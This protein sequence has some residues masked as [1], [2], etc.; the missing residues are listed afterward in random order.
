MGRFDN[1]ETLRPLDG[2]SPAS[3]PRRAAT[4]SRHLA[5][6]LL[7]DGQLVA[8]VRVIDLHTDYRPLTKELAYHAVAGC[9][10]L[11]GKKFQVSVVLRRDIE[12]RVELQAI[13]ADWPNPCVATM[14]VPVNHFAWLGIQLGDESGLERGSY[15]VHVATLAPNHPWVTTGTAGNSDD[16][17]IVEH[18]A[19]LSFPTNFVS[20][21]MGTTAEVRRSASWLSCV[22][23][24]QAWK[25]FL[26][27][28]ERETQVERSWLAAGS[29]YLHNGRGWLLVEQLLELPAIR[30]RNSARTLGRDFYDC[31]KRLDGRLIGLVHLHPPEVEGKPI[32]PQ[33]SGPDTVVAWNLDASTDLPVVVPIAMFGARADAPPGGRSDVAAYAFVGGVLSEVGLEVLV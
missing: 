20:A 12:S 28:A 10:E 31:H 15:S 13:L 11:A 5:V 14:H 17:E 16:F 18:T 22:F 21:P 27:A 19:E 3:A 8:P 26:T 4:D 2:N 6:M 24:R 25:A 32:G 9:P 23:S 30:S 7:R 33:P 1:R 29:I